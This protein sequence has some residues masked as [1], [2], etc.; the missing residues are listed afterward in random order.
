M[1]LLNS[2]VQVEK[3]MMWGA[4]QAGPWVHEGVWEGDT[5]APL[6]VLHAITSTNSQGS[7]IRYACF[8]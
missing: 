1:G 7:Y 2:L 4:G 3:A 8:T 5:A 6:L